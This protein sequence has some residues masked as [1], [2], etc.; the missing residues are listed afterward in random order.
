MER[1]VEPIYALYIDSF[2][3]HNCVMDFLALWMVDILMN[4]GVKK[5]R[6]L[7]WAALGS[8]ISLILFLWMSSYPL[9]QICIH[10]L[11]NPLMIL[12]A[13]GKGRKWEWLRNY[14]VSY[15]AVMLCGGVMQWLNQ[16]LFGGAHLYL[17]M[18]CTWG[19]ALTAAGFY[20]RKR[21]V[22]KYLY[23]VV[24][25][26]QQW[27]V[28]V[29]AYYDTGNL[30]R[31]PYT[32]FPV[33]IVDESVLP[34]ELRKDLPVRL[35]PFSSVGESSGMMQAVTLEEI[36]IRCDGEEQKIRP[37]VVGIA[38]EKMFGQKEYRMILNSHLMTG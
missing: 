21:Q 3:F 17:S 14:L 18:A 26:H 13:F 12:G 35:I 27:S 22:Q 8:V 4:R 31:D 5:R 9:Y 25:K 32:G 1:E 30:L 29:M 20:R 19:T 34:W 23:P 2:L 11:V 15:G 7:V 38:E 16:T 10:L 28:Q 37:A 36:V 24:L 33:S 6:L